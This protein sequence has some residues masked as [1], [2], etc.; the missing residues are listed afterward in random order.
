MTG[1]SWDPDLDIAAD[2]PSSDFPLG[3]GRPKGYSFAEQLANHRDIA[4]ARMRV[5]RDFEP[6][7]A[8]QIV[9]GAYFEGNLRPDHLAR[10]TEAER[11]TLWGMKYRGLR[12]AIEDFEERAASRGHRVDAVLHPGGAAPTPREGS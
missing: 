7:T 11:A 1:V 6:L 9:L 3:I 2:P 5:E 12:K 8:P 10:C 4:R